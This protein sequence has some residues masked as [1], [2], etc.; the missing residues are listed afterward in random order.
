MSQVKITP[1]NPNDTVHIEEV[2]TN[3][4]WLRD[5]KTPRGKTQTK[6]KDYSELFNGTKYSP[7]PKR[8][9]ACGRPGIGKSTF[10]Q[11]I[12]FDWTTGKKEVLKKFSLLLLIK[13][14]DVCGVQDFGAVLK[15]ARLLPADDTITVDNL[16]DYVVQNQEQV[17]L[18]LDGYDEY[19]AGDSSPIDQIWER[20]LLR[21][22]HVIMTTRPTEA[23]KVRK[24]SDV[25]CQIKGFDSKDQVKQF[26]SKYLT[27]PQEVEGLENYLS[28]ENIWDIAEIPL[29]LLMLC[30]VWK[31]RHREELPKSRLGLYER[32]VKTL[33][34]QMAVKESKCEV[35]RNI[36]DFY[37]EELT[38][39]G[40]L[41]LDALLKGDHYLYRKELPSQSNALSETMIRAGLFQV[42]KLSSADPDEIICFLHKTIQEYLAAWFI[43][44]EAGL[45]EGKAECL[46]SI[47][48]L[49]K[50]SKAREIL[51]FMC[52]WSVK[53]AMAVFSLLRQIGEK[54]GLTEYSFT[55][56]PSVEELSERQRAFLVDCLDLFLLCP[57]SDRQAVYPTFLQCVNSVLVMG[58]FNHLPTVAREFKFC[59]VPKPDYLF[60]NKRYYGEAVSDDVVSIMRDLET[61]MVTCSGD[62]KAV[63][64][65]F[66]GLRGNDFF[67]KKEGQQ[68]ILY[69]SRI[70]NVYDVDE[71]LLTDL[72]RAL[73]PAP[74]SA[75]QKP[76]DHV[77]QN[78]DNS[79]ALYLPENTSDQTHKHSLSFVR[80]IKINYPSVEALR[81]VNDI[82][83][84]VDRPRVI[85]IDLKYSRESY[86][87]QTL[88]SLT[89]RI[90]FTGNLQEFR[91]CAPDLS[92][93]SA[94]EICRSLHQAPNLQKLDLSGN[95]LHSSS[96]REFS[97]RVVHMGDQEYRFLATSLKYVKQLQKLDLSRNPLGQGITEL[98]KRLTSVPH[99][100]KLD[101]SDIQMGEEEVTG[102]ACSLQNVAE[103]KEL[104][105]SYNPLG[106]GI[107][108]LA[109][110]LTSV[111]HLTELRLKDTQM[112]EEEVTALARAL[113]YLPEVKRLDLSYNPLGRGVSELIQHLSSVPELGV[114]SLSGVKMT[115]IEASELCTAWRGRWTGLYTDYHV[116]VY[117]S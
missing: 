76:G 54:E 60:F 33:L 58:F 30:Y 86:D 78:Q 47:D 92:A 59:N 105:L 80:E 36:L 82:L 112:G 104:D 70:R 63:M 40:K 16:H 41:A 68:M 3:L 106:Q 93:K 109:K 85:D 19:S 81:V 6:L 52:Q 53:G 113:V 87:A 56:T 77:T 42:S 24:S 97:L 46:S 43:M 62:T 18:V 64:K 28:K 7:N 49:D 110:H 72:L 20:N 25:Q 13:L 27:Y 71:S 108:E 101:L 88:E 74:E 89:S 107:T 38:K 91:F 4:S 50:V 67:L 35:Q 12:A 32:F 95:P 111:P 73:S 17:L 5:G 98:A 99:L 26:A 31:D 114:L 84:F 22:C 66:S 103:L 83:P 21:D 8:I 75:S 1:W 117:F 69:L 29:L 37:K 9:L 61:V 10:S 23:D 34:Y 2:Y 96:E 11:K 94:T 15:A 79:S 102:V 55:D 116:S 57:A 65:V 14:R 44:H 115:K 100:T 45:T 51:S 48:S 90:P 39:I